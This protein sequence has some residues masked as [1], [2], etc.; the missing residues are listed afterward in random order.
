MKRIELPVAG[1]V[2]ELTGDGAGHITDT[3]HEEIHPME[4]ADEQLSKEAFNNMLDAITS[5]IL[6]HAC[7]G[8]DVETPEYIEGIE[9]A[10]GAC[11]CYC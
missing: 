9:T 4:D 6:G 8:V 7:A 2:I 10:L 11:G 1:I 3:M 5:L